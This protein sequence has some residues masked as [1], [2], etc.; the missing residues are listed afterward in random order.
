M[1]KHCSPN[2]GKQHKSFTYRDFKNLDH[3]KLIKDLEESPWDTAFTFD[4]VEDIVSGWYSMLNDVIN[5][6]V[7]LKQ[8]R[9]RRESKPK[10]LS[11]KILQL[12]K[13][14]DHLL[15]KAKRSNDP[16][17]WSALRRAEITV[18]TAIRTAKK[19][20]FYES[21]RESRGNSKKLW[22]ALKDLTGKKN[23]YR[24]DISA[25]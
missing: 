8:K 13:S 1:Y 18:T 2:K 7:P 5:A 25:G 20:F 24:C 11:P 9:V 3:A 21:F 16:L 14:R 15:K 19:N 4:D 6:H 17:D 23:L 10:W 12:M 22:S